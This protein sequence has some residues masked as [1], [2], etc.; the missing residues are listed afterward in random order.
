[1]SASPHRLAEEIA[2]AGA[3]LESEERT[4]IVRCAAS[5]IRDERRGVE[6]HDPRKKEMHP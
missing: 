3:L 6:E 5:V 1:M 2:D 4:A